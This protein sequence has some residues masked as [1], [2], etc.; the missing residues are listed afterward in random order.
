MKVTYEID[1]FPWQGPSDIVLGNYNNASYLSLWF[2]T[3]CTCQCVVF[4]F[5]RH[6]SIDF[7]LDFRM[8]TLNF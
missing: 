4:L 5:Y 8:L 2:N 3:S 1:N 7:N 6:P